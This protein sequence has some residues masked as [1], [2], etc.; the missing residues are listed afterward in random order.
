[1]DLSL[2]DVIKQN[3]INNRKSGGKGGPGQRKPNNGRL[4]KAAIKTF[5]N[6]QSTRPV[7]RSNQQSTSQPLTT[8]RATSEPTKLHVSNLDYGV[9]DADIKELF[10]ECGLIKR[11]AVH[12]DKSGRSLGTAEVIFANRNSA[13]SA[14]QKYHN[15]PLDGRPLQIALVANSALA[16]ARPSP[17]KEGR[18]GV[19]QGSG[20]VKRST[21]GKPFKRGA[22]NQQK[23]ARNKI[24]SRAPKRNQP[25]K[26]LTAEQLDADLETYTRNA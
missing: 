9:S 8:R 5:G 21:G 4:K 16:T 26:S 18:L 12:Y 14:I 7:R 22:N 11:A 10:A 24:N 15:V 13:T 6:K 1:M 19:K 17:R 20:V 3:R 2:D 25:R 23:G